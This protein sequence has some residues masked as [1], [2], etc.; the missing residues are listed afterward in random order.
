MSALNVSDTR[1]RNCRQPPDTAHVAK[2]YLEGL[3]CGNRQ[4]DFVQVVRFMLTRLR[5]DRVSWPCSSPLPCR[6]RFQ[7]DLAWRACAAGCCASRAYVLPRLGFNRLPLAGTSWELLPPKSLVLAAFAALAGVWWSVGTLDSVTR[8][9]IDLSA[10]L[11]ELCLLS[12]R[13]RVPRAL[14]SLPRLELRATRVCSP[15]STMLRRS[16]VIL[17]LIHTGSHRRCPKDVNDLMR[18]MVRAASS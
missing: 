9:M 5:C 17:F 11:V 7:A 13:V 16:E 12:M 4:T 8:F 3:S 18:T 14:Q 6:P 1:H 10:C 15:I 2:P